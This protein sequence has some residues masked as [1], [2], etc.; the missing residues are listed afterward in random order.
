MGES[1]AVDLPAID[2]LLADYQPFASDFQLEAFVLGS[3]GF[4]HMWGMY[5]QCLREL[6]SR[7]RSLREYGRQIE[8]KTAERVMATGPEAERLD[9]ALAQLRVTREDCDREYGVIY[10]RA[11][12]LKSAIGEVTPARRAELDVDFWAHKHAYALGI[13]LEGQQPP[14]ASLWEVLPGFPPK[15]RRALLVLAQCPITTQRYLERMMDGEAPDVTLSFSDRYQTARTEALA[16]IGHQK[17]LTEQRQGAPQIPPGDT[18][19]R[20]QSPSAVD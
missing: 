18:G 20:L 5:V 12:D 7:H 3:S 16:I 19:Y 8:E 10:E 6:D 15:Y 9:D 17:K 4:F 13:A 11:V 2:N 14:P 1:T